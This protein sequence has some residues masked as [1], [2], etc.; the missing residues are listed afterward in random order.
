[1]AQSIDSLF[2]LVKPDVGNCPN[3]TVRLAILRAAIEFCER[4]LVIDIDAAPI[5]LVADQ[6]NYALTLP[7]DT[8]LVEVLD[9]FGP[10]LPLNCQSFDDLVLKF[11]DWQTAK[12]SLPTDCAVRGG[13]LLLVPMPSADTP[14]GTQLKPRVAVKPT[15]TAT[16]IPDEL[17][18]RYGEAIADGAL[19]RL[20]KLRNKPWSDP[21]T[22][23][24]RNQD[25][26]TAIDKARIDAL[27][28]LAR[29]S[30]RAKP[31]AFGS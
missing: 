17:V 19:S 22:A 15:V 16:T 5:V 25:F 30:L 6:P 14:A 7:A 9:L 11:P 23:K 24:D 27:H 13:E 29:G 3:E 28:G 26:Q 31:R 1:M 18:N 20:L 12:S 21:A 10:Q 2:P 8:T 4:S